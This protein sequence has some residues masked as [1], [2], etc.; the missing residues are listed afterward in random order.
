MG[1]RYKQSRECFEPLIELRP[2][3]NSRKQRSVRHGIVQKV[4]ARKYHMFN[5]IPG[6]PGFLNE[7]APFPQAPRVSSRAAALLLLTAMLGGL[8]GC[9]QAHDTS[10]DDDGA[11]VATQPVAQG[12]TT[13]IEIAA[14]ADTTVKRLQPLINSGRAERLSVSS[15]SIAGLRRTLV[16]FDATDIA[17]ALQ[18]RKL[19]HARLVLEIAEHNASWFGGKVEAVALTM[20][21]SEG[22]AGGLFKPGSTSGATWRCANDT[23]LSTL[24]NLK[25]D[26]AAG[27]VWGMEP[28]DS[29]P[30]PF[31]ASTGNAQA[32][33]KGA[34]SVSFDVTATIAGASTGATF[35]WLLKGVEKPIGGEWIEFWARESG[36]GPK[37]VLETEMT[38]EGLG[39]P[40]TYEEHVLYMRCA[41]IEE[42][43]SA[44]LN[45]RAQYLAQKSG[46]NYFHD[47][48]VTPSDH[49]Y[50]VKSVYD[51]LNALL[52]DEAAMRAVCD[53]DADDDLV[54]DGKDNCPETKELEPADLEGCPMGPAPDGPPRSV[55][56]AMLAKYGV[57][58]DPECGMNVPVLPS[59]R[60]FYHY[61]AGRIYMPEVAFDAGCTAIYQV[62]ALSYFYGSRYQDLN[63]NA[64]AMRRVVEGSS[65]YLVVD[66]DPKYGYPTQAKFDRLKARYRVVYGNGRA[67]GW[68][69]WTMVGDW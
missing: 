52:G 18:G 64:A 55:V 20:P 23:N 21:W 22:N 57:A 53:A 7:G 68:T 24:G 9:G 58:A 46:Q 29:G 19:K 51:R 42:D 40:Q 54:A 8:S 10:R 61:R 1:P 3:L 44:A 35:G 31:A 47:Q 41:G 33:G 49:N 13:A 26:C 30:E 15:V 2:F 59:G 67:T 34:A 48:S 14:S 45:A 63:M 37:L 39:L 27:D 5:R 50:F 16:G 56:D 25:N 62:E 28:P 65:S 6:L 32:L 66:M 4:S 17:A 11:G 36:H 43:C 69:A 12:L 38:C 60:M